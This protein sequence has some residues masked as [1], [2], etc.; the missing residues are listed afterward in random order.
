MQNTNHKIANF[1]WKFEDE[2]FLLFSRQTV[3]QISFFVH[4]N[5]KNRAANVYCFKATS[6][7]FF[8]RIPFKST[9]KSFSREIQSELYF[10]NSV[11]IICIHIYIQIIYFY[12]PLYIYIQ[13]MFYFFTK[14]G[15]NSINLSLLHLSVSVPYLASLF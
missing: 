13:I 15:I 2:F 1:S 5:R 11:Y 9:L 3:M 8:K 6:H 14:L 4:K 10:L 12:I 7:H